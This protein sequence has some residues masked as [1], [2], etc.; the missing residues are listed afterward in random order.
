MIAYLLILDGKERVAIPPTVVVA[1]QC[2]LTF[3][4]ALK[5]WLATS[6]DGQELVDPKVTTAALRHF[7]RRVPA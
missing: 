1:L 5:A 4:A 2:E 6:P 7:A 3:D